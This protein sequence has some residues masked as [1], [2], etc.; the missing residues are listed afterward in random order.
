MAFPFAIMRP[1]V[2]KILVECARSASNEMS[3]ASHSGLSQRPRQRDITKR[4]VFGWHWSGLMDESQKWTGTEAL[5][6]S[7]GPKVLTTWSDVRVDARPQILAVRTQ[8]IRTA[9]SEPH[10]QAAF[11]LAARRRSLRDR[12]GHSAREVLDEVA[13]Q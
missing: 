11:P 9:R 10:S 3:R 5:T 1:W 4:R 7:P 13:E 6:S 2:I 8:V 12:L